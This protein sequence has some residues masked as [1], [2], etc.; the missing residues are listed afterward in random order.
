MPM[1][2]RIRNASWP[3][4]ALSLITLA[5]LVVA[6]AC[7]PLCAAQNCRRADASTAE[8]GI[9]HGAATMPHEAPRAHAILGCGSPELPA[10][11]SART[12]LGDASG[13]S[14]LRAPDG[15]FLAVELENSAPAAPFSDFYFSPP[16]DFSITF[17]AVPSSVLRIC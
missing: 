12:P 15:K 10:V 11:V 13:A 2:M 8:H 3:V 16:Q 7:A 14:S 17:A 9:C 5:A 1:A 6:P 4:R